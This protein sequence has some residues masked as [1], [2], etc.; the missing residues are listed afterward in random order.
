[1]KDVEGTS[2]AYVKCF[3]DKEAGKPEERSTDTHW[4]CQNG[5]ASFNWRMLFPVFVDPH[6]DAANT[7]TIQAWDKDV[8]SSDDLIGQC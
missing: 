2:D 1:M 5:K 6:N 7:L 3:F 4:R 8:I